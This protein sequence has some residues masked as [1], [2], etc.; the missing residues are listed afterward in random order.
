M[1]QSQRSG[2]ADMLLNETGF[3]DLAF[4][5]RGLDVR[6]IVSIPGRYS[7]SDRRDA[8]GERRVFACRAI[9]VSPRAIALAGPVT[10]KLGERVLAHIDH[11]GKLEGLIIRILERGFVISVSASEDERE[12]LAAKIKWLE[13]YKNHDANDQRTDERTVPANPYSTMILADGS[14]ESCVVLDLSGSGVAISADTVPEVGTVLAIGSVVGRVARHFL[15]GFGVEF[16]ER[17]NRDI[18]ESMVIVRE[19]ANRAAV[20]KGR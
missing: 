12:R 10:G 8:R 17:Q 1:Q 5:E 13:N 11:L 4:G 2:A 14:M 9:N 6:I 19:Y 20:A 7:L 16:I 15:G 3:R 18:V